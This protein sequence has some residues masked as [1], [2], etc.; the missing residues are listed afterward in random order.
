M[1]E[2]LRDRQK[3]VARELILRAA[4]DLIVESGLEALSLAAVAEQ[5][6]VSKR[7]LYNYFDS[8]ETLLA[9]LGRWSDEL[10]LEQGGYLVPEG[11]DTLPDYIQ[12]VWRTWAEQGTIYQAVMKVAASN[13]GGVSDARRRRR[14]AMA[15]AIE[16]L[17]PDLGPENAHELA[18]VFHAIA[19]GPVF[20]RLTAQDELSVERAASLVAW[21]IRTLRDAL[22]SN[23]DPYRNE[24]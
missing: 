18:A 15:S 19:S 17:R 6:G 22:A 11:L 20:E 21:V 1:A 8:R 23:H 13:P 24:S 2:S 3:Q 10:T 16:D 12:A 7:T 14:A 9:E 5:A 4:A